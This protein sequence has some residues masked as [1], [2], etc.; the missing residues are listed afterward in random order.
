M[1]KNGFSHPANTSRTSEITPDRRQTTGE[2]FR[3]FSGI[4]RGTGITLLSGI[5]LS[6]LAALIAYQGDDP[7]ALAVPLSLAAL[8]LSLIAGGFITSRTSHQPSFLCGSGLGLVI[9]LLQFL[10]S[11]MF[12]VLLLLFS[13]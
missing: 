5:L 6:L 2:W 13:C 7:D 3:L 12:P 4:L 11:G 8:F 1:K 10:I 9:L